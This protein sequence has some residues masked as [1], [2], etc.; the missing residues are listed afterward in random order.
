MLVDTN[1]S[2]E[3]CMI[4]FQTATGQEVQ[5]FLMST[6]GRVDTNVTETRLEF[7]WVS[8]NTSVADNSKKT[9]EPLTSP[10]YAA[11]SAGLLQMDKL[12]RS[13]LRGKTRNLM[14]PC[15]H[16]LML[17]TLGQTIKQAVEKE[18]KAKLRAQVRS[19]DTTHD[20]VFDQIH[21]F[22]QTEVYEIRFEITD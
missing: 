5:C 21:C 4:I 10:Q 15:T 7:R 12:T 6:E 13:P 1:E 8:V 2:W 20:H 9:N 3:S 22:Y 18:N 11:R 19:C 14:H 16:K 17:K